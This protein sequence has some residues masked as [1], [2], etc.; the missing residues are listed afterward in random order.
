MFLYS[1]GGEDI[2]NE[3]EPTVV[4]RKLNATEIYFLLGL[5]VQ[6]RSAG[7]LLRPDTQGPR[8]LRRYCLG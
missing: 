2:R 3:I 6:H 8:L 1:W 7:F 5:H 4:S